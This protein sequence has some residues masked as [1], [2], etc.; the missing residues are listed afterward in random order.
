MMRSSS[1]WQ[2]LLL[3]LA[4]F[5]GPG[6]GRGAE[7]A[8]PALTDAAEIALWTSISAKVRQSAAGW[9][10][11]GLQSNGQLIDQRWCRPPVGPEAC[12][13]GAMPRDPSADAGLARLGWMSTGRPG[14]DFGVNYAVVDLPTQGLGLRLSLTVGGRGLVGDQ[15]S[16]RWQRVPAQNDAP[17]ALRLGS[18]LAWAVGEQ[19]IDVA[20]PGVGGPAAALAALAESPEALQRRGG[21]HLAALEAAVLAA[22]QGDT[23]RFCE[24]G[25]Y[26]GDGLPPVCTPRPLTEAERGAERARLAETLG[27]WRATLQGEA[28]NLHAALVRWSP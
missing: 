22:L 25:P 15:L 3:T 10:E 11:G 20:M 28:P 12:A 18:S 27:R 6:L 24:L 19:Q 23:L 2:A 14:G 21:A 1:R 7:P 17:D 9:S 26:E 16:L 4:L 5:A 13:A 8:K